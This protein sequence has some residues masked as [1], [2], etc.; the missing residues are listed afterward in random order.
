MESPQEMILSA[1]CPTIEQVLRA[2]IFL[3]T[4]LNT[5]GYTITGINTYAGNSDSRARQEYQVLYRLVGSPDFIRLEPDSFTTDRAD[6]QPFQTNNSTNGGDLGGGSGGETELKIA[7]S[8]L[9]GVDAIRFITQFPS[10][11]SSSSGA[12]VYREFDVFGA[13]AVPEPTT[14]VL[15][16]GLGLFGFLR[17]R[18]R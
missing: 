16:S 14:A 2:P 12:S 15:L 9:S 18:R 10:G 4:S 1:H 13:A 3:D 8:G 17:R 6:T 5:L 7:I 11:N